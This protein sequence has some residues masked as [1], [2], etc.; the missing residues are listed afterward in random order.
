MSCSSFRGSSRWPPTRSAWPFRRKDGRALDLDQRA[1]GRA[2]NAS[3]LLLSRSSPRPE[4]GTVFEG[5][6]PG[7]LEEGTQV[8]R[9][10]LAL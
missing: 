10:K 8:D 7:T 3:L 1:R 9:T 5:S 4:R 2:E 6:M